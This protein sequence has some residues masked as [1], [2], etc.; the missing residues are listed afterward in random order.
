M[1]FRGGEIPSSVSGINLTEEHPVMGY[2]KQKFLNYLEVIIMN[3]EKL[4]NELSTLVGEQL[5]SEIDC[6]MVEIKQSTDDDGM[7]IIKSVEIGE[8]VHP[9]DNDRFDFDF[10]LSTLKGSCTE[11]STGKEADP[12]AM[13]QWFSEQ[14]VVAKDKTGRFDVSTWFC[15]GHHEDESKFPFISTDGLTSYSLLEEY[16]D[17]AFHTAFHS[18]LER[19]DYEPYSSCLF[20]RN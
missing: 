12:E 5:Q 1:C 14:V 11:K 20:V 2:A 16:E 10:D 19:L 17:N 3:K 9:T 13:K 8:R 18:L 6:G 7:I 15:I 4:A